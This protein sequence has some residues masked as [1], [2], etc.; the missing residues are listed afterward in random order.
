MELVSSEGR[1]V[2][3]RGGP[4]LRMMASAAGPEG[5]RRHGG[6]YGTWGGAAYET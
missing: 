6:Q 1:E 3:G 2:S 4:V 5:L